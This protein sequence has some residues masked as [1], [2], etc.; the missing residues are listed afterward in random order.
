MKKA[1]IG[2]IGCGVRIRHV[3]KLMMG[4][5]DCAEVCALHDPSEPAVSLGLQELNPNA[6]VYSDYK[7]LANDPD[8]DWV[9]IG[10]WNC[11]HKEQAIEALQAGKHVFCEKP[12]ATTLEDCLA[13]RDA[14]QRSGRVFFIGFTLRFSPLYTRIKRLLDEGAIGDIVSFEFNETLDFNH[15]GY[16]HRDWRR[17]TEYA[18]THLLE[19]CCHD[20]DLAHWMA[21]S[22]PVRVGSFG[23]TNFFVP[24]NAYHMERIGRNA[25]GKLAYQAFDCPC[26]DLDPFSADKD[27]VDNQVAIVEFENGVRASFHTNCNAGIP[28][29]RMYIIGSEG[30]IRG[31]YYTGNLE[32]RQVG[33]EQ[34]IKTYNLQGQGE[35]GGSD[36][37]LAQQLAECIRTETQP[38]VGLEDGLAAAVT[39]F[40][41]DQ[42]MQEKRIVELESTW[43]ACGLMSR[44]ANRTLV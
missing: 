17:R 15:G 30:T 4:Q 20:I 12:L 19:K 16:I 39:C 10:S 28:E 44:K 24:S 21:Q 27:I 5:S 6:R 8:L 14:W 40:A 23:G 36:V 25:K 1:R 11:F 34:A 38:R 7:E 33:W 22:L 43:S 31:D 9:F 41:I 35:H 3:L 18:G 29:R 42:A 32:L 37:V 13:I 2:V 26:S